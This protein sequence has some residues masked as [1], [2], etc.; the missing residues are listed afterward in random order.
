MECRGSFHVAIKQYYV[1]R[2]DRLALAFKSFRP[3]E[4][5]IFPQKHA[6]IE[7]LYFGEKRCFYLSRWWRVPPMTG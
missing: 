4:N 3:G 6:L 7:Q 2:G 1:V 5:I